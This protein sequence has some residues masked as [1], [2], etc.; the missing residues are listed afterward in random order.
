MAAISEIAH[1]WVMSQGNEV[2]APPNQKRKHPLR[3]GLTRAKARDLMLTLLGPHVFFLLTHELGWTAPEYS[4][5]TTAALLRELFRSRHL[6][7]DPVNPNSCWSRLRSLTTEES[8][9]RINALPLEAK[10]F[11]GFRSVQRVR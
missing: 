3:R 5:W 7:E 9:K 6:T 11:C 8:G 1:S 4:S 10:P 2:E